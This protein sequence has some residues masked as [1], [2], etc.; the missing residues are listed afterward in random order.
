MQ[1]RA[2]ARGMR[3]SRIELTVGQSFSP[4]LIP[5]FYYPFGSV[6]PAYRYPG[7]RTLR[8]ATYARG[9]V[10]SHRHARLGSFDLGVRTVLAGTLGGISV[11]IQ[12]QIFLAG[13]GPYETFT[14]PF[15]RSRGAL[16]GSD[17]HY[18][19]PGGG[20][21]RGFN[22]DVS[23]TWLAG[24]NIEAGPRLVDRPER[25]LFSSV[26]LVVFADGAL[27]DRAAIDR[28]AAAD[29]GFGIRAT[30]RVGPT[31]FVTRPS[32]IALRTARTSSR[33]RRWQVMP[34]LQRRS[35]TCTT[36]NHWPTTPST[37]IP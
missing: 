3:T 22:P 30:H 6:Y 31:R 14:N 28:D 10:V 26:S 2:T 27:L 33:S 9:S 32:L 20:D 15:L 35:A 13:A 37:T 21:L 4:V 34:A 16:F 11:P 5:V 1:S 12:R 24:V 19:A 7:D 25:R 8:G 29:A 36:W 23:A 18:Q 17:A